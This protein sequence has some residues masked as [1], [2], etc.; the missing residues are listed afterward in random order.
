MCSALA[1]LCKL[2][3][4]SILT[5][6]VLWKSVPGEVVEVIDSV[7]TSD[8][9]VRVQINGPWRDDGAWA[10]MISSDGAV[11]FRAVEPVVTDSVFSMPECNTTCSCA[12]SD[13]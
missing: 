13:G 7:V 12:C 9:K 4:S 1:Q 5:I 3:S 2:T 11:L 8:G 6:A 10:S